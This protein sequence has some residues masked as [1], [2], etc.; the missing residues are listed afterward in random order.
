MDTILISARDIESVIKLN[1]TTKKIQ[2]ILCD[3]RFWE[4]TGYESYVLQPEGDFMY[5]FQQH[6]AYQLSADLDGNPDTIELSM[7]DNHYVSGRKSKLDYYDNDD[8]S[9]LLVYSIDESCK[10]G[11]TD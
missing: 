3:P 9:Y 7:F 5:H 6:T 1:W 10:N 11:K 4:G 2:W 8:A